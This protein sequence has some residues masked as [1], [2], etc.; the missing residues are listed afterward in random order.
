MI[1]NYT[2]KRERESEK[3]RKGEK[4]RY[5]KYNLHS[6]LIL[7]KTKIYRICSN[8]ELINNKYSLHSKWFF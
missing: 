6:I 8:L 1:I 5:Y 2:G 3:E 7:I 4:K